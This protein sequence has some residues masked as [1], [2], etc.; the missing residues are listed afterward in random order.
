MKKLPR[1]QM[2]YEKELIGY[3]EHVAEMELNELVYEFISFLDYEESTPYTSY[4]FHPT[5][6]ICSDKEIVGPL[7]TLLGEMRKR[8]DDDH[9]D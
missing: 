5:Q 1:P 7:H 8:V 6:L 4:P 9:P 2:E 3:K